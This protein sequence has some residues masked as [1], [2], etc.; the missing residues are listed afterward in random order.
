MADHPSQSTDVIVLTL[1]YKLTNL[2]YVTK[3]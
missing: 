2:S 1:K 3:I